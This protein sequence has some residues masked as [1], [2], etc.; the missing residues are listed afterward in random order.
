MTR[1]A[2]PVAVFVGLLLAGDAP[3]RG[4]PAPAAKA[5]KEYAKVELKG[6]LTI[7]TGRTYQGPILRVGQDEYI[8]DLSQQRQLQGKALDKLGGK[9]VI[10][11]GTLH[12]PT[13]DEL[14][15]HPRVRV[16]ALR[17]EEAE[18][19]KGDK[20]PLDLREGVIHISLPPGTIEWERVFNTKGEP[21]L[22]V[23]IGGT[24]IE[25]R[26]VFIGDGKGATLYEA[27]EKGIHWPSVPGGEGPTVGG[28]EWNSGTTALSP[29][30]FVPLDK[31]K[32]G[33]LYLTTQDPNHKFEFPPIA[34]DKPKP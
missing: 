18:E 1:L 27:T 8:L 6:V 31:L 24:V 7:V 23:S 21:L 2:L 33:N 3:M 29:G 26:Q 5:E 9:C 11:S 10:L 15:Q 20:K 25:A 16:S 14:A 17:V 28:M 12:F 19:G 30:D 22:R 4:A 13:P 32:P 34:K